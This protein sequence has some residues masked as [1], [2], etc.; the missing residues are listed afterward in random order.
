MGRRA[1]YSYWPVVAIV[2]GVLSFGGLVV[3]LALDG[4][5]SVVIT[6]EIAFA[7]QVA[8]PVIFISGGGIVRLARRAR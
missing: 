8:G 3:G 7:Q 2:L 4:M 1:A 6:H 5:T